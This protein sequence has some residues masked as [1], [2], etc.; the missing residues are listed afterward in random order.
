MKLNYKKFTRLNNFAE[1][2]FRKAEFNWAR[3]GFTLIEIIVVMAVFLFI[4]GAAIGLFISIIDNQKK[5]LAQQQA[6][7]QIS[8]VEE[9][10]SKA[11]R[12]ATTDTSGGCLGTPNAGYIYLLTRYDSTL[13]QP[14]YTGVKFINGTDGNCEEY[15]WDKKGNG[16][17]NTGVLEE[18][19]PSKNNGLPVAITSPNMQIDSVR[20][21]TNG[22]ICSGQPKCGVSN[23]DNV[24]PKI[25]ILLKIA[26]DIQQSIQTTVSQRNLNIK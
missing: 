6:L 24:Q 19:S 10:M 17:N 18:F 11:L 8:Y 20:F 2:N 9:Y 7:S 23:A 26:G 1:R 21:Y 25:T 13:A 5:I 4:I 22:T 15:Y 14:Q 16:E 3:K 12:M